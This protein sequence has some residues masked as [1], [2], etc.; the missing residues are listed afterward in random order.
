MSEPRSISFAEY[1]A[2]RRDVPAV[3]DLAQ[4][5]RDL[6]AWPKRRGNYERLVKALAF[7]TAARQPEYLVLARAPWGSNPGTPDIAVL[8][9]AVS[10]K[11]IEYVPIMRFA[12]GWDV[13]DVSLITD[14]IAA[15]R[16]T[17]L[18]VWRQS[19]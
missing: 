10:G 18:Q 17:R 8:G 11:P 13:D 3:D 16:A 9:L 7:P 4:A 19:S 6:A 5:F 14:R 15:D 12:A 1:F 2:V